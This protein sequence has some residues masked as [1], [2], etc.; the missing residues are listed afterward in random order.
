MIGTS[1]EECVKILRVI[2]PT[3]LSPAILMQ[4]HGRQVLIE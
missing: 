2:G 3:E 1:R 4:S